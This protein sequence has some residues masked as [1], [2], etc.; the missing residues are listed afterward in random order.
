MGI[1]ELAAAGALLAAVV[2][3]LAALAVASGA[4]RRADSL[5]R[6][7]DALGRSVER[8]EGMIR[9]RTGTS[10]AAAPRNAS[11]ETTDRIQVP[12][13]P[14]V[15][16]PP[17]SA[18]A[19][20]PSP[21]APP[22]AVPPS[23]P[24]SQHVPPIA[25][26]PAPSF[27]PPL[28]NPP[29]TPFDWEGM[30]GVKLFSW[31]AGICL[32]V[33]ALYFLNYSIQRGW[34]EAPIRMGIGL[35]AGLLLLGLCELKGARRYA[36]T[37][38]ALDGAGVAILFSTF[39]AAHVVWKLL[40]AAATFAALAAVAAV[41]VLLSIRRDS[42]FIAL[43]GLAGGFATPALLATGEDHPIGLFGYLLLLNAGLAWV[44]VR[45]NWPVLSFLSVVLTTLYQWGWVARFLTDA[46]LPTAAV[47][48]LVF[49]LV[50][51][52]SAALGEGDRRGDA[53]SPFARAAA[54][55]SVLPLLFALHLALVPAY[56]EHFGLLFGFLFF[57][58]IGLSAVAL[59]RGPALLHVAGAGSVLLVFAAWLASSWSP[60]AWPALLGFL[61]LFVAFFLAAPFLAERVERTTRSEWRTAALA[62]P[63][64]LLAF[65]PLSLLDEPRRD[66]LLLTGALLLL[67]LAVAA[68]ALFLG[69]GKLQVAGLAAASLVV[70]VFELPRRSEGWSSLSIVTGLGLAAIGL[71]GAEIAR[72]RRGTT[73]EGHEAF[74]AGAA[75]AIVLGQ[76]VAIAAG[77]HRPAVVDLQVLIAAQLILAGAAIGLSWR[78]GW[79]LFPLLP[80]ALAFAA[81]A[82]WT[83]PGGG[84][85]WPGRLLFSALVY[86][87]F[88]SAPLVL[89]RRAEKLREPFLL[90]VLAS[91]PFFVL[92]R[93]SLTALGHARLIGLLPLV[94][95]ALLGLLLLRLLR[96]QPVG[97]RDAGRLAL[98]AGAALAFVTVAM[99]LQLEKEWLT[100]GWALEGAALA[101]LATRI[102]HR[103]LVAAS[104]GLLGAAFLRLALN[105]AVLSYHPKSPVPAWNWFLY[106]YLVAAGAHFAA[107]FFLSRT[108][109]RLGGGG[110]RLSGLLPALGTLLLFILVNLEV[111]DYFAEGRNVTFHLARRSQAEDLTYTLAWALFAIALLLVGVL[112]R[113]APAR[114]AAIGLLVVTILKAFLHDLASLGGLSRVASF[115]GLAVSLA[116]VALAIQR[117]VLPRREAGG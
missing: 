88:L 61:A 40:P 51:V 39:F 35:G 63:L 53:P 107:A 20:S 70:L 32:V 37:A 16:S 21:P 109:D 55:S 93:E 14:A 25:A 27:P 47:I 92:A 19:P 97:G 56:G 30:V 2:A 104:A 77:G 54:A 94:Q 38:N 74:S 78:T 3:A 80:M 6:S 111:A 66:H 76:V 86:L 44:A 26:P 10:P 58:A 34:L 102:P 91:V 113:R 87:L 46:K 28:P 101:W 36:V 83:P 15:P 69:E 48:F 1:L 85:P 57:V 18:A 59:W 71:A 31:L 7:V 8:L 96:L 65:A 50:P 60:A 115:V 89:G 45:R 29:A 75:V 79:H 110:P 68:A 9:S 106:A 103:G 11:L 81:A 95:A 4:N 117:F 12:M 49:P 62:A 22:P 24:P 82:G 64:L 98:V 43:L 100:L 73:G 52:V 33:G 112:L 42:L 108:D 84:T 116:L 67:V 23:P 41:A 105:P 114:I 13:P 5:Q 90:A 99:P 72:R 17:S